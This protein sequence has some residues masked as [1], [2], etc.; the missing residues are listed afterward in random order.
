MARP[1]GDLFVRALKGQATPKGE[2]DASY[3]P[4]KVHGASF[5]IGWLVLASEDVIYTFV[6]PHGPHF[7]PEIGPLGSLLYFLFFESWFYAVAFVLVLL[8]FRH[9]LYSATTNAALL[10]G[11]FITLLFAAV[12][13]ATSV[14]AFGAD[15]KNQCFLFVLALLPGVATIAVGRRLSDRRA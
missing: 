4:V 2:D 7:A 3:D 8:P 15:F 9:W 11:F 12:L 14:F 1:P 13:S 10:R 5:L 6:I